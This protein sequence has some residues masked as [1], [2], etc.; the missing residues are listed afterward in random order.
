MTSAVPAASGGPSAPEAAPAAFYNR[1][2]RAWCL[3]P[4]GLPTGDAP[5]RRPWRDV[6]GAIRY[7]PTAQAAHDAWSAW[8]GS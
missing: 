2:E 4:V 5:D 7:F 3:Y 8:T 1:V 6:A